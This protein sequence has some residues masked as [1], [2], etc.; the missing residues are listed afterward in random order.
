M[1]TA[2]INPSQFFLSPVNLGGL[3][4]LILLDVV[5]TVGCVTGGSS[6][7]PRGVPSGTMILVLPPSAGLMI[8]V[9][10][11]PGFVSIGY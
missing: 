10:I 6:L 3:A 11:H 1:S 5:M 7:E 9:P 2:R 4:I 8:M